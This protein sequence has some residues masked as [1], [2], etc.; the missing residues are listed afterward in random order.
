MI[1]V[2]PGL[3]ATGLAAVGWTRGRPA[4]VIEATTVRTRS[5]GPPAA[6]LLAVHRSVRALL[7][8]LGP[9]ALALERLMWGKNVASAMGVARASGVVLLAAAEAGIPVHEYAPLEVK[10]AVTGNGAAGKADVRGALARLHGLDPVPTEPDAADAV[11]VA[12][13]HLHQNL[14]LRRLGAAP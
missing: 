13:C 6:R 1:G 8:E 12:L 14:A 10:M 11:A 5:G 9:E 4:S 2:D 3:A 7:R